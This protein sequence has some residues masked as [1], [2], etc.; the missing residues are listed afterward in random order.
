M[1]MKHFV[2]ASV[3]PF[4]ARYIATLR[5]VWSMDAYNFHVC[6]F[7]GILN[8]MAWVARDINIE[9]LASALDVVL[10]WF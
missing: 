8:G 2:L 3:V 6:H 9:W 7:L 1:V 4:T 5:K 10:V